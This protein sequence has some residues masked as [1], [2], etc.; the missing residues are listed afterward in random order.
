MAE[1]RRR[2]RARRLQ[3]MIAARSAPAPSR[4]R[5]EGIEAIGIAVVASCSTGGL[6]GFVQ[7]VKE[8]PLLTK[9]MVWH[10]MDPDTT[11]LHFSEVRIFAML[12]STLYTA[13]EF[14]FIPTGVSTNKAKGEKMI[15]DLPM[16]S[17]Q[18][19]T[20]GDIT[21]LP[22]QKMMLNHGANQQQQSLSLSEKLQKANENMRLMK[23]LTERNAIIER[24]GSELQRYRINL[25][26]VQAQNLQLS[27]TNTRIL[28]EIRT[29]KDQLKALQHELSCKNGVLMARKLPLEPQKLPCT[30][31]DASEDKDRAN[32]SHG[33]SES[34]IQMARIIRLSRVSGRSNPANSEVLDIIGRPGESA[35]TTNMIRRVSLRR[36]SRRFNIQELGVTEN[37][38][39]H[40]DQESAAKAGFPETVELHDTKEITGRSRRVSSRRHSTEVT[41]QRDIK[42]STD[43][44]L[45]DD[46]VEES[47]QVSSSVST[48]L[49]RESKNKPTGDEAEEMRETYVGRPS[50]Q[51]AGKIKSYKEVSL[52][53][54]MRRDF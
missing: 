38:G 6:T 37:F 32:A 42:V 41:S 5:V 18:R 24:T 48:E 52:K 11:N 1:R 46:I 7:K 39:I 9:R 47:S 30:H 13:S 28:A 14:N 40:D 33:A 12:I 53:D 54:K 15:Q 50:R 43:P 21:N 8:L 4:F 35:Q 29:S 34:F 10:I 44:P 25:Q 36:Q 16:N 19:R 3:R 2:Y 45:H 31:H 23:A 27:Q 26:M 49:K 22:N 51:A 20:L 17:A